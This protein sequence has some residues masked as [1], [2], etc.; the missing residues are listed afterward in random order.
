MY[1]LTIQI[2]VIWFEFECFFSTLLLSHVVLPTH[3]SFLMS[4]GEGKCKVLAVD[5]EWQLCKRVETREGSSVRARGRWHYP[6]CAWGGSQPNNNGRTCLSIHTRCQPAPV[7]VEV[8]S[9]PPVGSTSARRPQCPAT[10]RARPS[11]GWG[12]APLPFPDKK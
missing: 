6:T 5:P 12:C 10:S 1:N 9:G 2:R 8:S 7:H 3:I 4:N 11:C